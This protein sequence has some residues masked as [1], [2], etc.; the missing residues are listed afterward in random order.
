MKRPNQ[1][2]RE[3]RVADGCHHLECGRKHYEL[4][5]WADAYDALSRGDQEAPLGAEDLERLAMA[6]YLVGRDDEYLRTLER[7]HNAYLNDD[8]CA[9]AVRCAFWLGF[10]VLMRGEM[11]RATGWFARAQR[12]LERDARECAERGYLLLPTVGQGTVLS[13][14]EAAYA[15][16]AEAAA[17][18]ERCG[19]PELIACARMEQGRIRLQQ[20]QVEAGLAHLDETMVA[21]ISGELSPLVT[22]LMYCSVIEACQQ[23]YAFDRTREWTVALTRWCEGQPDMVAFVGACRVHRAEIMQ[24][25]GTWPGSAA[26]ACAFAGGRPACCRCGPLP[27]SR[28]ASFKRE[29]RGGGRGISRCESAGPGAPTGLCAVA[30]HAGTH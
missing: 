2:N 12:V 15:A 26:G 27:T 16:A 11:G 4:R 8:E 9:R 7:A 30:P 17:I 23:V 21:V 25:R 1:R 28:G 5:A 20:G 14:Y 3:G 19:D 13:N 18:G 6:A 24:L 10:R 29:V 22:G